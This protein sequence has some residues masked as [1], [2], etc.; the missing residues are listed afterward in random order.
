MIASAVCRPSLGGALFPGRVWQ[1]VAARWRAVAAALVLAPA[2]SLAAGAAGAQVLPVPALDARVIDRTGTLDTA[3]REAL[4]ARLS[5][6]EAETGA[7]LVVLMVPATAPEDIAAYAHRVAD[8]WKLGRREVGDGLLL[9][10]AKDERKV[11]IEVAKSLEGAVPDLAARQVIDRAIRPAFRQGDYAG[12]LT[13][14][15][16]LLGARIRSEHLPAPVASSDGA[17]DEAA[18]AGGGAPA[19]DAWTFLLAVVPFG[20][21]VLTGLFGRVRGSLLAGAGTGVLVGVS[22]GSLGWGLLAAVVAT[23]LIGLANVIHAAQRVFGRRGYRSRGADAA[24]AVLGGWSTGA[25]SSGGGGW[26][27]GDDGGGFSSGGGGDF[28]GGGASGDW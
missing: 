16:E 7:Q 8:Q 10:V 6:L 17:A 23:V 22:S 14:A 11:R 20:A 21:I 27:S 3:D 19:D 15:V 2:L 9:V 13:A 1:G 5:S 24:G 25:W 12:G 18:G 26:S 28:G 4:S